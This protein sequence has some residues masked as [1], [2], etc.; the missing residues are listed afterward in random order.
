MAGIPGSR[1][2]GIDTTRAQYQNGKATSVDEEEISDS[3]LG[4]AYLGRRVE[5]F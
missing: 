4:V 1:N 3:R 2:P 5:G